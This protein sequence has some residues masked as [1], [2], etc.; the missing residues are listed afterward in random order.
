MTL[1][2]LRAEPRGL[3]K[4]ARS[5]AR[6]RDCVP[7]VVYGKGVDPMPITVDGSTLRAYLREGARHRLIRLEGTDQPRTVL[8][9]DVQV[10]NVHQAVIHV[11]F[12]QPAEGQTVRLRV[13]VVIHGDDRLIK[14]GLLLTHQLHEVEVACKAHE[15]PAALTVDVGARDAGD[16]IKVADLTAPAG[17]R[18]MGDPEAVLA[19]INAPAV[20]MIPEIAT[21]VITVG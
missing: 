1:L 7:A 14:R 2:T 9:K 10:D 4:S 8:I 3:T 19:N 6:R 5:D 20:T 13:P 17:V 11:D 21:D 12:Y 16:A 18:I 15:V